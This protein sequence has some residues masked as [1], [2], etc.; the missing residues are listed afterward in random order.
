MGSLM[1][2]GNMEPEDYMTL[3]VRGI[4][5]LWI[6]MVWHGTKCPRLMMRLVKESLMCEREEGIQQGIELGR[7][8]GREE[9]TRQLALNMLA[10]GLAPDVVARI[11]GLTKEEVLAL[12]QK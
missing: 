10:E 2:L 7:E 1:D 9:R 5:V 11:S 12:A 3:G 6:A 4:G 8:E